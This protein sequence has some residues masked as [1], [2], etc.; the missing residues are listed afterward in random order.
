MQKLNLKYLY[1]ASTLGLYSFN[2]N[3]S[4]VNVGHAFR[5]NENDLSK[6]ID[7]QSK[8][9]ESWYSTW[10][11]FWHKKQPTPTATGI[12]LTVFFEKQG[13]GIE[14]PV[15]AS[16]TTR[17]TLLDLLDHFDTKV[18]VELVKYKRDKK[19]TSWN[20]FSE[21][22]FRE[23]NAINKKYLDALTVALEEGYGEVAKPYIAEIQKSRT[24]FEKTH[25][26]FLLERK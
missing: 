18:C 19:Y 14:T 21:E 13:N 15:I 2:F 22:D 9:S 20:D 10:L 3:I 25:G 12:G 5:V 1:L 11:N 4:A 23:L 17:Y 8:H 7:H 26:G 6:K 16:C 24:E